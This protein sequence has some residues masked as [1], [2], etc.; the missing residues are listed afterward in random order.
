MRHYLLIGAIAYLAFVIYGSLVPLNFNPKSME[1]ALWQFENIRYLDL[2]I[3]SL[4]DWVANILLIIPLAFLWFML[5]AIHTRTH[6]KIFLSVV[7]WLSCFFLALAIEFTQLFF[8]PRTVSINDIIAE[9]LG[10]FVG[11]AAG[12]LFGQ[13]LWIWLQ[14]WHQESDVKTFDRYLQ[15]YLFGLFL[16]AVLPL[17]L[18]ISPVELYHKW[19]EGRIVLLP[20]GSLK[21]NLIENIYQWVSE[22]ALWFPVPLLW[23][24]MGCYNRSQLYLRVFLAALAIEFFQ[25]FVY[26]RV[27]DVTDILL[28]LLGASIGIQLTSY[29]FE[30][31]DRA[32]RTGSAPVLNQVLKW[33]SWLCLLWSIVLIGVFWYPFNFV[34]DTT[35]IAANIKSFFK[36]PFYAYYYGTEF[37]AITEVFHKVLF[38]APLGVVLAFISWGYGFIAFIRYLAYFWIALTALGIEAG[39]LLLPDKNADLT[40][41]LLE[42][43]GGFIGYVS[44]KQLLMVQPSQKSMPG[45]YKYSSISSTHFD[46]RAKQ[47]NPVIFNQQPAAYKINRA[48][49]NVLNNTSTSQI[50]PGIVIFIWICITVFIL[51]FAGQSSSIPYNVRELVSGPYALLQCFGLAMALFWCMGFPVW[52]LG[53]VLAGKRELLWYCIA[54]V[55]IHSLIAWVLIRLSAPLESIHDIVGSPISTNIPPELEISLRFLALFGVF[56]LLSF[57]AVLTVNSVL[58]FYR[59]LFRYYV[60]GFF[61]F[62]ILLPIYY[63]G[64]VV[65]AATDNVVELLPDEGNSWWVL[66]VLLYIFLFLFIGSAFSALSAFKQWRKLIWMTVAGCVSYPLGYFLMQ[67]GTAQFIVKYGVMFSALQ[68]LLSTDRKHYLVDEI[69]QLRFFA[70]HTVLLIITIITQFPQWRSLYLQ[71]RIG[72]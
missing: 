21:P 19:N 54:G 27:T 33:S 11:I 60:A 31:S 59:H 37:R 52:F 70:V 66:L 61:S 18:T 35:F 36:V 40:D 29:F 7:I 57:G 39:Q 72:Y 15:I 8:P 43:G 26:S 4:A 2:G 68:F 41:W 44:V 30:A 56:S 13:P 34:T 47:E 50:H 67:W 22:I 55:G 45:F 23:Q 32:E 28:A 62:F 53:K 65:E 64:I 12:W 49:I 38:F 51:F 20:F 3:G 42:V 14:Q 71:Q 24:R 58:G 5:L 69:L 63:W 16:Y 25:L 6:V 48:N 17:D 46:K 9:A 10:A 1:D